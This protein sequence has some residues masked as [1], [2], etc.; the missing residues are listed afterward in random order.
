MSTPPDDARHAPF[1]A[2]ISNLG[3]DRA[4]MTHYVVCPVCGG[5]VGFNL[6]ELE[7][8]AAA[9][10]STS[11]RCWGPG[12]P[13]TRN[14]PGEHWHPNPY[15]AAGP[16]HAIEWATPTPA[17]PAEPPAPAE[18]SAAVPDPAPTQPP[19]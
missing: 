3:S 8:R 17:A 1:T 5:R 10:A 7:A 2:Y 14:A 18:A 16:I 13:P 12:G 6:A 11:L 9:G 19:P 4:P 15:T